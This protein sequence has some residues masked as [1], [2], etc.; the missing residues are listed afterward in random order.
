MFNMEMKQIIIHKL[1]V[2]SLVKKVT[3]TESRLTLKGS[4]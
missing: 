4:I 2:G 3:G 1:R